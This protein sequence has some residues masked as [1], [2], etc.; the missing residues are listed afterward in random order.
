M[1][2]KKS[3]NKKAVKIVNEVKELCR[4]LFKEK[5]QDVYLYGSYA[6][7]DYDEESDI[8]ILLTL[9]LTDNQIHRYFNSV[10][11]LISTLSLKYDI[12][13]SV[14]MIPIKRFIKFSDDLPFYRNVISEGINYGFNQQKIS[15]KSSY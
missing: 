13:V 14:N 9:K 2:G 6:R 4:T 8:D 5:L 11:H 10:C 1:A 3:I 7:G 12:T 15:F